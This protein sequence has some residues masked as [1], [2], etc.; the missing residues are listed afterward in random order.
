MDAGSGACLS[1]FRPSLQW[2]HVILLALEGI[3]FAGTFLVLQLSFF[4]IG[5]GTAVLEPIL[6]FAAIHFP[7]PKQAQGLPIGIAALNVTRLALGSLEQY[8][9]QHIVLLS[10]YGVILLGAIALMFSSGSLS[11]SMIG[12]ALLY[13]VGVVTH[14]FSVAAFIIRTRSAPFQRLDSSRSCG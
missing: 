5:I 9:S 10:G 1:A 12:I 7:E 4:L 11:V 3:A 14:S 8:I 6:Y 13:S 2:A